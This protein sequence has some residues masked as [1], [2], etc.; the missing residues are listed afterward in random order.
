MNELS[1]II[2]DE[3]NVCDVE[4]SSEYARWIDF[5]VKF[6]WKAGKKFARFGKEAQSLV[7]EAIANLSGEV[8]EKLCINYVPATLT[9]RGETFSL[10]PSECVISI[11]PKKDL[12][13]NYV[14]ASGEV[15]VLLLD[16]TLDE[17][18]TLVGIYNDISSRLQAMRKLRKL[19]Y[20]LKPDFVYI[21]ESPAIRKAMNR[22]GSKLMYECKLQSL[23]R[24]EDDILDI[25][26]SRPS[27][28][29]PHHSED[30]TWDILEL[31]DAGK[32]M[33]AFTA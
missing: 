11:K 25:I 32:V 28:T 12:P 7:T 23:V 27:E 2:R 9:I 18:L 22:F 20:S 14:A 21:T 8:V 31:E 17:D 3:L 1:R 5:E 33:L 4:F 10:L 26:Q 13:G 6:N 16:T 15:G 29:A 30:W 19:P 24:L